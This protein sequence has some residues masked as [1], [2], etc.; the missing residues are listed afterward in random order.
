[1]WACAYFTF[2]VFA[3]LILDNAIT[4]K[5]MH[6]LKSINMFGIPRGGLFITNLNDVCGLL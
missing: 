5:A 6:V 2:E 4:Y 3:L 1:M